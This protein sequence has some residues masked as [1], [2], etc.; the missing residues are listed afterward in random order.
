MPTLSTHSALSSTNQSAASLPGDFFAACDLCVREARRRIPFFSARRLTID[1]RCT[2][3]V[4][5]DCCLDDIVNVILNGGGS[6]CAAICA[7]IPNTLYAQ[8]CKLLCDGVGVSIFAG[9]LTAT[10]TYPIALCVDMHA[11]TPNTCKG[12]CGAIN[13]FGFSPSV[14]TAGQP[15]TFDFAFAATQAVGTGEIYLD[16]VGPDVF[17]RPRIIE[18]HTLVQSGMNASTLYKYSVTVPTNGYVIPCPP[19]LYTGNVSI[20]AGDCLDAKYG[21]VLDTKNFSFTLSS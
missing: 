14:A 18:H 17:G 1:V 8:V 6:T 19:G 3:Y 5:F 9:L 12:K 16:I 4:F 20:C 2:Q 7:A 10:D 11:C 13:A 15:I 21:V